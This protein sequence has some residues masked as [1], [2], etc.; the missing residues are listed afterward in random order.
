MFD[1]DF[2]EGGLM[3]MVFFTIV[4]LLF[5]LL[6]TGYFLT[7][8]YKKRRQ[9]KST[10]I[11]EVKEVQ[12]LVGVSLAEEITK[13]SNDEIIQ[14]EIG[15]EDTILA[16]ECE[17]FLQTVQVST[18]D[19]RADDTTSY[20]RSPIKRGG[21][22][23]VQ[24]IAQRGEKRRE[25]DKPGTKT[26]I[27]SLRMDI[28]CWDDA[29]WF[30]GLELHGRLRNLQ[31]FQEE[32]RLEPCNYYHT[33][34]VLKN[35][36]ELKIML[37]GE[38]RFF[39]IPLGTEEYYI[40]KMKK[41]W[42]SPGRLVS[43]LNK[44]NYLI[45]TPKDWIRDE[46]LNPA[47][48]GE[49]YVG[50]WG[51]TAH[52]FFI[53]KNSKVSFKTAEGKEIVIKGNEHLEL[54]GK[55]IIDDS[56]MGPLFIHEVPVL[57]VSSVD[58]WDS[59]SVIIIGREGKGT[60]R[61]KTEFKPEYT[62]VQKL[63][64]ILEE[65]GCGWYYIRIYDQDERLKESL[66][67]RYSKGLHDIVIPTYQLPSADGYRPVELKFS[68]TTDCNILPGEDNNL[69]KDENSN[70]IT[71]K[72]PS[73]SF[74]DQTDWV[75][76]EHGY[77][78]SLRII[79]DRIWWVASL[80][81]ESVDKL[82]NNDIWQAKPLV[83]APE[84]FYAISDKILWIKITKPPESRRVGLGFAETSRRNYSISDD[85][86]LMVPL[87]DFTDSMNW[88]DFTGSVDLRL[89]ISEKDD[90]SIK[91]ARVCY[92]FNCKWCENT[93]FSS[94]NLL[95]HVLKEHINKCYRLLRYKEMQKYMPELPKRIYRC[96][97]CGYYVSTNDLDPTSKMNDHIEKDCQKAHKVDPS[98]KIRFSVI[99]DL[100]KI[101]K[102]VIRNL[103]EM[104]EC[105][106]CPLHIKEVIRE[107]K[108]GEKKARTDH[109]MTHKEDIIRACRK[110]W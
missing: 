84:D 34:F 95:Q 100:Y 59:V 26:S 78:I 88:T 6:L 76:V 20:K 56:D 85:K 7:T 10:V 44:G 62:C 96:S 66:D 99:D 9:F 51:L 49:E 58:Y 16:T 89:W 29:Q 14:N 67:F 75:V 17:E 11:Q 61:W 93:F 22:S 3:L 30:I 110:R 33:R 79:L 39:P 36:E 28:I 83:F 101:R 53:D 68:C 37:N 46:E 57:K 81:G 65:R 32:R 108:L 18:E 41:D 24:S 42:V 106:L 73:S 45:M 2:I 102:N 12:T 43:T 91:L 4:V 104:Y 55:Q 87:N 23:R 54:E 94:E 77:K 71:Y 74:Y 107:R 103:P 80:K 82:I 98:S 47:P 70:V 64:R 86:L 40:F 69:T 15:E 27:S 50:C 25:Q 72:L 35:Q 97:Y 52:F 31:V 21:R 8:Q 5:I 60:N 63:P 19:E 1:Q 90:L 13:K 109:L 105:L 38:E 92:E 48:F